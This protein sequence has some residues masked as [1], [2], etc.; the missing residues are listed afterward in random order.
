MANYQLL[1]ADI[2][3][4]VY[5]NAHREITG[6][7]LN[8]VLNAMVTTLGAEY[9]FAGVATKDTN[10]ETSDAKV[11]Y[12]ANGKGTYTNFGGI[13]VTEDDVVVLYWDSSWHKVSTG[14]ASQE[15]LSELNEKVDALALGAFY[16]YFP[17]SSSLPVDVTTPGYAYVGSDNPYEIWNFNGESWSDS[18]TSI[19]MNDADEEDITRNADGKLQFKDRTY[20]DGMGYVILRKDKTFA[21]QVTQAN[22]IYEIRYDFDLNGEEIQIKEG[23]VLSFVGGSLSNGVLENVGKCINA[24]NGFKANIKSFSKTLSFIKTSWFSVN[25][26]SQPEHNLNVLQ[27]AL[28]GGLSIIIDTTKDKFEDG[29]GIVLNS[30]LKIK[31]GKITIK[32]D[33]EFG[34]GLIFNNSDAFVFVNKRYYQFL[35]FDNLNITS[36]GYCFNFCNEEN[37]VISDERPY[38]I[39]FSTFSN[40]KVKSLEKDC[41]YQGDATGAGGDSVPI[42]S[43]LFD[44]IY[45]WTTR[46]GFNGIHGQTD[47]VVQNL[48]DIYVP[49]SFF[50]NTAPSIVRNVN[51]SFG[52]KDSRT[53]HF[54]VFDKGLENYG[55]SINCENC[56]WEGYRGEIFYEQIADL[57]TVKT[58][59]YIN[60]K[61]CS[62]SYYQSDF[63]NGKLNIY[64]ITLCR[65]NSIE[66]SRTSLPTVEYDTGY[67]LC[68][69]VS[70]CDKIKSD[71]D[72]SYHY[73][74][75][76]TGEPIGIGEYSSI[77]AYPSNSLGTYPN[78]CYEHKTLAQNIDVSKSKVQG[79]VCNTINITDNKTP[80][81]ETDYT[82]FTTSKDT[83]VDYII[84]KQLHGIGTQ[85]DEYRETGRI[86]YFYNNSNYS[87]TFIDGYQNSVQV[88]D[89]RKF[90]LHPR[91]FVIVCFNSSKSIN[92]YTIIKRINSLNNFGNTTER[93]TL[94]INEEGF[95]YYDSTLKKKILW[96]GTAWTN[97][98]GTVL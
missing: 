86:L 3:A 47:F 60:L 22:T 1:K 88:Q 39:Y 52:S 20:G 67:S 63:N 28:D 25:E 58:G 50:R 78:F 41:F 75:E 69:I 46:F 13:N 15:K 92:R 85:G 64:P 95:E 21:E 9:Q 19:D 70:K 12:I 96:N 56:S 74:L 49:N 84:Y 72:F 65:V 6:E 98:D 97:M 43:V 10:P 37:G 80:V 83:S 51:S 57:S 40:L 35:E 89:V 87:I 77:W 30:P 62:F 36:R 27:T 7:N 17:D 66:F 11:F 71:L 14:I 82:I 32:G 55:I 53:T 90:V 29:V 54:M 8:A 61:N 73:G 91:E 93:P 45:L 68:R 5:E 44:N 59:Y 76:T 79:M 4:K 34:G 24:N 38:N 48:R 23:C 31:D 18:G 16:G 94:T 26:N 42:F 81:I 33:S 2:D